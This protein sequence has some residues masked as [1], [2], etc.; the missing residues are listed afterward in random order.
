MRKVFV[1]EYVQ[2]P[3]ESG[4]GTK[5]I[6]QEKDGLAVF[7][8]FGMDFEELPGGV[9]CFSTAI[10]EWPNGTIQSVPAKNVRFLVAEVDKEVAHA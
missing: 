5:W 1:S 10:V 6:L 8:Q 7:H 4:F 2:I 9:A 3:N